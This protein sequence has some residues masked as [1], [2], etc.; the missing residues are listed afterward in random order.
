MLPGIYKRRELKAALQLFFL[1]NLGSLFYHELKSPQ[2]LWITP[3]F[4]LVG[5]FA[6]VVSS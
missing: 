2:R 6:P 4:N 1:V 3:T 5:G